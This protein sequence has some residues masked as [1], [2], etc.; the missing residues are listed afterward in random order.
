M[1]IRKST[2]CQKKQSHI[3]SLQDNYFLGRPLSTHI[4]SHK[5]T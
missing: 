5:V 2:H 4:M 3:L 1:I